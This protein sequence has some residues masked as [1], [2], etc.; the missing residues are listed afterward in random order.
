MLTPQTL[1]HSYRPHASAAEIRRRGLPPASATSSTPSL[2]RPAL[3]C[4]LPVPQNASRPSARLAAWLA[5]Q[6][7]PLPILH[8][9]PLAPALELLPTHLDSRDTC[10]LLAFV[11]LG[12]SRC[13]ARA[14]HA[15]L[16]KRPCQASTGPSKPVPALHRTCPAIARMPSPRLL[17]P[18]RTPPPV[19]LDHC[20]APPFAPDSSVAAL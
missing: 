16:F 4:R 7:A 12:N 18:C 3:L 19:L 9:T 8:A 13:G 11:L 5:R 17:S 10:C 20:T 14:R 2:S 1:S 6:R 15:S